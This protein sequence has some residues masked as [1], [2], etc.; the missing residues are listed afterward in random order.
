MKEKKEQTAL[1]ANDAVVLMNVC[2]FKECLILS[3]IK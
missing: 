2:H 1:S 3:S